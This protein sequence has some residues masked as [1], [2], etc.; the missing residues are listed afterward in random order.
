MEAG[1]SDGKISYASESG[2]AAISLRTPVD[3]H[4]SLRCDTVGNGEE[5]VGKIW[6]IDVKY[7]AGMEQGIVAVP[8]GLGVAGLSIHVEINSGIDRLLGGKGSSWL[9]WCSVGLINCASRLDI[10]DDACRGGID[11]L[12]R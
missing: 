10:A 2:I 7:F 1:R 12:P 6:I 4:R 3:F 9:S 8:L 5:G 11:G